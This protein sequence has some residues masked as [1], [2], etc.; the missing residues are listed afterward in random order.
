MPAP[1]N[2]FKKALSE[3][4]LQTGLWQAIGSEAAVE[5]CAGTGYDWLLLDAEHAPNDVPRLAAQLRA[6]RGSPSHAVIRPP[7][8]EA[9]MI[10]QMLDIGA[11][12][13]LIPMVQDADQAASLVQAVRY[14]PAGIRGVGAALARA[15]DF[16]RIE[17]Y[18]ETANDEICLLVQAESVMALK[19]LEAICAV[20]GVDGVF[21]GPSDLAADMGLL[22]RP[23]A[24][25][26]QAAVSDAIARITACGKAA[27]VL[28]TDL[29]L[30][31]TYRQM[32]ASFIAIG[33]DVGL[34]ATGAR[35]LLG[36]FKEEAER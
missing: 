28:S 9:W 36:R 11:Q 12:T 35:Q 18:L 4:Q 6:M 26:V 34:L 20:E 1:V 17:G 8:G 16:N 27:G 29:A 19:N 25:Q 10:K 31:R 24:P 15:S 14:P 21:I 13:L 7:M 2:P 22:G 5:I 32:G 23:G 33:H 30:A 3:G